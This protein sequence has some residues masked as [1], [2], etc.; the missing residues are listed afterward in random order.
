L[1]DRLTPAVHVW[2]GAT[3]AN[4]SFAANWSYG[5]VPGGDANADL[6]YPAFAVGSLVS[7]ND[8]AVPPTIHSITFY[9]NNFI[10]G[11]VAGGSIDLLAG[12]TV[13]TLGANNQLNDSILLDPGDH[14]FDVGNGKTLSMNGNING[15]AAA[16]LTKDGGKGTLTL[17]GNSFYTGATNVL[18][19]TLALPGFN[20]L[21][22]QTAVTVAYGATLNM[23]NTIQSIGSLTGEGNVLVGGGCLVTG[24]DNTS[25]T[26]SGAI[27]GANADLYKE[28]TGTFTLTGTNPHTGGLIGLNTYTGGT[29]VDGGTLQVGWDNAVPSTTRGVTVAPGATF[30]VNGFS[31]TIGSLADI[32]APGGSVTLGGGHLFTGDN[33]NSTTFSGVISGNGE[34]IKL[35]TGTFTLSGV[36]TYVGRTYVLAGILQVGADNAV[37]STTAVLVARNAIFDVNNHIDRIGS[38]ADDPV[39]PPVALAVTLGNGCLFAGGDNSST[40]FS[41]VISG[42]NGDLFKEGTGTMTLF[43]N[44]IYTGRTHVNQGT[45]EVNG[46]QPGSFVLVGTNGTLAGIG[47][48]GP[49]SVDGTVSPSSLF[50]SPGTL[51]VMGS[52]VF[53]PGSSFNV[54]L[55]GFGSF[56]RLNVTGMALLGG[57]PTLNACLGF[58]FPGIPMNVLTT[59]GGVVGTFN[60]LPLSGMTFTDACLGIPNDLRIDYFALSVQ[61][62]TM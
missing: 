14:L 38:L 35:G 21:S 11:S 15:P 56:D 48:V 12:S 58:V 40:V 45:L 28:G 55:L 19:G 9:G 25:T 1:E 29:H 8:Y 2:S 5:G 41:G 34:L 49:T 31:D 52:I 36:N 61:L 23:T 46:S 47:T 57:N 27:S 26:F 43:G 16:S 42:A 18:I 20:N 32:A 22:N 3:G 62:T 33:N 44:N 54:R 60:G 10:V 51:T 37:P 17:T 30:D 6:I 39:T 7:T 13:K 24:S 59:G 50:T 4:W 53:N